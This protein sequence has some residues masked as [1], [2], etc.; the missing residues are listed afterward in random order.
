M[1]A[2]RGVVRLLHQWNIMMK[3]PI[4][5]FGEVESRLPAPRSPI[6]GAMDN[7]LVNSSQIE[8]MFPRSSPEGSAVLNPYGTTDSRASMY[9]PLVSTMRTITA[10][11]SEFNG[12]ILNSSFFNRNLE[13]RNAQD[14]EITEELLL[15]KIR[16]EATF[17]QPY[18]RQDIDKLK[19]NNKWFNNLSKTEQLL[20]KQAMYTN[21]AKTYNAVDMM[22]PEDWN[23]PDFSTCLP[24]LPRYSDGQL[25]P[26]NLVLKNIGEHLQCLSVY[27]P[28]VDYDV[29]YI[30]YWIA[31][32]NTSVYCRYHNGKYNLVRLE[33]VKG[34][35]WCEVL[36]TEIEIAVDIFRI[37]GNVFRCRYMEYENAVASRVPKRNKTALELVQQEALK[38]YQHDLTTDADNTRDGLILTMSDAIPKLGKYTGELSV[39]TGRKMPPHD[40]Q[41]HR[42][43]RYN[44][45][46]TVRISF[47]VNPSKIN[48]GAEARNGLQI[49]NLVPINK[50]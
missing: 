13:I 28:K 2:S 48:G 7:G 29:I 22:A 43:Y 47:P 42:S 16:K 8:Q 27:I 46:G 50:E 45:D 1:A 14:A 3:E 26:C 5:I 4:R 10:P 40:R 32:K 9:G 15:Q 17:I 33:Y 36:N 6:L 49:S 44:P 38:L 11:N 31:G 18:T 19:I 25:Q 21:R 35:L 30:R 24:Y 37:Y 41:A 34:E 39:P 23:Q 20:Y 12:D